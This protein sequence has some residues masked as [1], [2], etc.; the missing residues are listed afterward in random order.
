MQ[1]V[2]GPEASKDAQASIAENPARSAAKPPYLRIF[3]IDSF[4]R[5]RRST[6]IATLA[7]L[8]FRHVQEQ[9]Q[10]DVETCRLGAETDPPA[11]DRYLA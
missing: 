9:H 7:P 1:G 5:T 6:S 4:T 2:E 10:N 11:W 3:L 8:P